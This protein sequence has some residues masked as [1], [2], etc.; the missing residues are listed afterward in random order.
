MES[1]PRITLEGESR[2][3]DHDYHAWQLVD[4]PKCSQEVNSVLPGN[5]YEA[6]G[7]YTCL[8]C[9]FRFQLEY[10]YADI[11]EGPDEGGEHEWWYPVAA[12]DEK[13]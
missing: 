3:I 11:S 4:C 5:F 9:G 13:C 2:S 10:E 8:H 6:T 7:V 1:H 12:G